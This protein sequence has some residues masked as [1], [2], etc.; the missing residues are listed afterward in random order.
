MKN[1]LLHIVIFF[2]I[3][4]NFHSQEGGAVALNIPAR[5]SLKFNRQFINPTFSFVRESN[6]YISFNNKREWVQFDNAPQTYLFG[7]SGRFRENIGAG[8]TLFQQDYGVLTTFGGVVNFAYNAVLNRDNNLTFGINLGFYNSGLNDGNVVTN[9]P[10][11]TLDNFPS[12]SIISINPGINYGTD[13]FDFG[14]S[15]KNLVSYNF[16]NSKMIEDNPEQG[17]QGHIMYTGYINSRGFFDESKFSGLISSE[18]KKDQTII[19]GMIMLMVPK[20]IWMQAGYNSLYAAS[21]GIG[22]NISSNIAIEYNFEKGVGGF[23]TFG[24]S[25]DITLAYKFINNN[26]YNY[27]GDDEEEALLI[28]S[29]KKNKRIAKRRNSSKPVIRKEVKPVVADTKSVNSDEV[30]TNKTEAARIKA[31]EATK[32]KA[33]EVARVQ[34]EQEAQAKIAEAARIKA[35]EATKAKAIEA[36]RVQAEQEA[37]AKIVEAARIK[38][39][40]ATKAKAIE[41]ARVQA[42]QEA[43]AKIAEA[44]RIKAEKATKAKAIEVARVQAEQE[45][46]AKIVEAA[47]IKAEEATKAKAIEVARVQAEQEAQAKIVE[48]ARIK[49]EEATKAKVIEVARVQAEQEA[50]A[51]IAEAARIKAEA[52]LVEEERTKATKETQIEEIA[53]DEVLIEFKKSAEASNNAQQE[54]LSQLNEKVAIKQQDLD[55]LKEENDLSEQGI[56]SA[57]KAFKSV[58]AENAEIESLKL[59]ID[60]AFVTGNAK[61]TEIETLYKKRLK[62]VKDKNDAV[63]IAYANTIAELKSEQLKIQNR[64]QK[65]ILSLSDIKVATD[66]ERR[67]RIKRAEYDNEDDRYIKDRAALERIKKFTKSAT[68]PLTKDDFDYG[69]ELSNIQIVKGV[70]NVDDGYYLVVAVHNDVSKRDEFLEKAVAAGEKDI[71]FFFDLN[72][73]K[74]YIYYERFNNI[75]QAKN[76]LDA[77]KGNKAYNSKMSLVKIEN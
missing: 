5:N 75:G 30:N 35:E 49:A 31:E 54:L 23:S 77:N 57:P 20:G 37:Q 4:Q 67:R 64:R 47:R 73:S 8:V 66:F 61:I 16:T 59:K 55:D 48:A 19:S 68:T 25:H 34:A 15:V 53:L 9:F 22:L 21:A 60:N 62:K 63:N 7:Y 39:E 51:K 24:N 2:C 12:N 74:Y 14:I 69:E 38:A 71:N 1:Y 52:K 26:R 17:I 27:S 70:N 65:L 6:K 13:F 50:Q 33:I 11:S 10:D 41:A 45:V 43:Q 29:K 18:F 46:Q 76:S 72:T 56:V 28:A 32:A 3:A 42:E 44:A 40:E 36:A 58:S